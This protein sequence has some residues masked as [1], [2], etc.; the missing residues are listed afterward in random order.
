RLNRP[1]RDAFERVRNSR[2]WHN[3][4]E[5]IEHGEVPVISVLKGGVIGGGLELAASTHI[6]VAQDDT[7][8]QLPEGQH[9]ILVGGGGSVRIPRIIGAGRVVEMMLTARK[10]DALEG[11]QLGLAHYLANAGS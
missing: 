11:R 2:K 6:R 3:V 7:F 5:K 4:F 8:V 9:G 1:N 10:L